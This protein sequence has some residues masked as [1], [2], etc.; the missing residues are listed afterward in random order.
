MMRILVCG[1]IPGVPQLL[2]ILPQEAVVCIVG[3]VIRPQYNKQLSYY[4]ESIGVPFLIQPKW[5][6]TEY[7]EFKRQI[8]SMHIDLIWV[9]SYSMIIREDV[10]A[11]ARL[12]GLNIHAALLPR[13]RG[14]NPT[15]WAILNG[16]FETGVTLHEMDAGVD[17][18]PI[19]DQRKVPIFFEDTW[20]EVR[21]R[22]ASATDELLA[23]NVSRII[24]EDW[25]ATPQSEWNATVGRRRKPEDG[26]FS[27]MDPIIT[28]YNKVR[29]LLPPLPT[30]YFFDDR[31]V[32]NEVSTYHTIWQ[33]AI[34]KYES[35]ERWMKA[36]DFHL[37]PLL[38][39]D[40]SLVYEWFNDPKLV[41]HNN[42]DDAISDVDYNV[43]FE[44][45]M[46][47][48]SDLV[49]F[50]I[51]ELQTRYTVGTCQLLNINWI[52]HSAELRIRIA[53]KPFQDDRFHTAAVKLLCRF[54][55]DDLN[56]HRIYLHVFATNVRAI[57]TYEKCGFTREGILRD[58]AFIAGKWVDVFVMG[59]L[60]DDE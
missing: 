31:G 16:D 54:A 21:D 5:Q 8:T 22:L 47:T 45:V 53:T 12:G 23:A 59:K 37:R 28:I 18:G 40:T 55:F 57:R 30:A 7:E 44:R 1:D 33:L 20:I 17:T 56:L 39:S 25:I 32:K 24:K 10:L 51:E 26:E 19:I 41:I 42:P 58:A 29:A 46:A 9:N 14:C 38:K 43:W 13:N 60:S 34:K 3:A 36:D 2:R 4:A 35:T 48:R 6:S 15:Q 11:V 52:H 50:V 27:W 49:I